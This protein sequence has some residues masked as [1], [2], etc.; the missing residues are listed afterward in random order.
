METRIALWVGKGF[1]YG[2]S[3]R[4]PG[5]RAA[6]ATSIVAGAS[7]FGALTGCSALTRPE[8]ITIQAE[9]IG[10]PKQEAA[11]AAPGMP[12]APGMPAPGGAAQAPGTG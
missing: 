7:L 10:G 2:F 11:P 12:G 5:V 4:R 6:S 9:P 1:G 3:T 8:E